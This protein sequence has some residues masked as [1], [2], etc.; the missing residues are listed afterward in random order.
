M[1]KISLRYALIIAALIT[2]ITLVFIPVY[3]IVQR[4]MYIN[5]ESED[6]NRFYTAFTSSVDLEDSVSI[7]NY[8]VDR[9]EKGYQIEIYDGDRELIY[10]T[11]KRKT[12]DILQPIADQTVNN[13][14]KVPTI[15]KKNVSLYSENAKAG[16][17]EK[18]DDSKE[19]SIE[20]RSIYKADSKP[21]YVYI[22]E[23]MR[24]I[25]SMFSYT[26]RVL[27]I[28]LALYILVC[29]V[30]LIVLMRGMTNS[31]VKLNN[32]VKK[33]SNKDYSV[34]YDGKITRDEVGTLAENFNDMADTIQDNINSINNYNFLLK[35]DNEHL[36]EYENMR[37]R[38]VRNTT[39]ELKTPL[40]IIS[41][42][43]EMMNC[44]VDEEKREYYYNSA[45]QEIQHMSGL[46]T[47]FLQYSKGD[48]PLKESV[49]ELD[50]SQKIVELCDSYSGLM[51]TKKIGFT[52]DIDEG[53]VVEIPEIH[54][55]HIFNN[56]V[57]NAVK[58]T[59]PSKEIIVRLK[60]QT[61]GYRLSVYNEGEKISDE[62]L[63][64]I[65]EEFF[66][67]GEN[68]NIGLGL[69]IVK[70]ISLTNHTECGVINRD[71][72]VEFWYDFEV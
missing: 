33:I 45:M 67:D 29:A 27:I 55:E 48:K 39:H 60:K 71:N 61:G 31:I 2:A 56:F 3:I 38:F 17:N 7:R 20:L 32:V 64:E 18:D 22:R 41:S 43:V 69:Y 70:E 50:V 1:R 21:F 58:H 9:N 53:C 35:E 68:N 46:I 8:L 4:S 47:S 54:V 16:F 49:S 26:N 10:S 15:P 42:Q 13:E 52:T 63:G 59:E 28:I 19:G 11:Q 37:Q 23:N 65:W 30:S 40:A 12:D 36:R 51:L 62:I 5:I 34:R 24:N 66:T 6:M 44:T 57:M 25:G 14:L 72:G